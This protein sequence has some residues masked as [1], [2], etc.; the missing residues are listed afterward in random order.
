M[1]TDGIQP[2]GGICPGKDVGF[3]HFFSFLRLI[4]MRMVIPKY[5]AAA[6][7]DNGLSSEEDMPLLR[8]V[9]VFSEHN[10]YIAEAIALLM[11][12]CKTEKSEKVI[13][14]YKINLGLCHFKEYVYSKTEQTP[15]FLMDCLTNSITSFKEAIYLSEKL[16]MLVPQKF[17]RM[18][19]TAY[20][21]RIELYA[22]KPQNQILIAAD[23]HEREV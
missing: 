19:Y 9:A 23:Q 17:I 10:A 7:E 12:A 16:H 20:G 15:Q 21:K 11:M 22:Q 3:A 5:I 8:K 1:L 6:L 13:F 2:I 14:D 4:T 18:L